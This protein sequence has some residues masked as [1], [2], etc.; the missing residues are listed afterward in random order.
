MT[1]VVPLSV[2][3]IRTCLG[4]HACLS[5]PTLCHRF[6]IDSAVVGAVCVWGGVDGRSRQVFIASRVAELER[7]RATH[8]LRMV[9]KPTVTLPWLQGRLQSAGNFDALLVH[10]VGTALAVMSSSSARSGEHSS[11]MV[12]PSNSASTGSLRP[13]RG[14]LLVGLCHRQLL[15]Q[16][17]VASVL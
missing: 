9:A 5:S 10:R 14:A 3:P 8:G 17:V 15:L 2:P 11:Q 1:P 7:L 4:L 13:S 12:P 6:V 16:R